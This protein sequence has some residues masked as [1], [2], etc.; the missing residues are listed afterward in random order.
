MWSEFIHFFLSFSL[1]RWLLLL[2]L[3]SH[4]LSYC[5]ASKC[6]SQAIYY[7]YHVVVGIVGTRSGNVRPIMFLL[8]RIDRKWTGIW[9]Q[10][11]SCPT[12]YSLFMLLANHLSL[13]YTQNTTIPIYTWAIYLES[14]FDCLLAANEDETLAKWIRLTFACE[15]AIVFA[16]TF[17]TA[18]NAFDVL[19]IFLIGLWATALWT[20]RL[21]AGR[22]TLL[23]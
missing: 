3:W 22:C 21:W 13:F 4:T 8:C 16:R 9:L 17:V 20:V 19:L 2:L 18:H 10:S 5:S 23:H 15:L 6:V 1:S 14:Q 11:T 7:R 12:N